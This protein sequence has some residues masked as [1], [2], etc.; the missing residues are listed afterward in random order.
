MSVRRSIEISNYEKEQDEME[1]SNFFTRT[2]N[3]FSLNWFS[4]DFP[5]FEWSEMNWS[6][7]LYIFL[8]LWIVFSILSIRKYLSCEDKFFYI[9]LSILPIVNVVLYFGDF[10]KLSIEKYNDY[11]YNTRS[12]VNGQG[13][14]NSDIVYPSVVQ[15]KMKNNNIIMNKVTNN[16]LMDKSNNNLPMNNI[17][18]KRSLNK[19]TNN[20]LMDNSTNNRLMNNISNKR[21][22]NNSTNNRLMN[23]ISNKRSLNNSTNI[24]MT[25]RRR[26]I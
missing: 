15:R 19:A 21:S 4:F 22:L 9:M 5:N 17:S 2:I 16:R 7:V 11:N 13:F 1:K 3:Y 6:I 18:N 20:R 25:N 12:N 23:N 14:I 8:V 24:F 10:C 26:N